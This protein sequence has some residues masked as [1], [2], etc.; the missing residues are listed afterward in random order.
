M[1]LNI[2][3][4]PIEVCK[5]SIKNMHLYVKP[6]NGNVTVSAPLSMSDEAI[7]RFVRTKVSWIKR[8]VEKFD[9]QPRQ[10]PREYI[11]GETLYVWGKQYYLR[12]EY[13]NK[14]SLVLSGDKAILTVRKESTALQRE[15]FIREW[16]RGLL[17]AEINAL[18]PKCEKTTGLKAT[19]WQTKYMTSR[20]GTCNTQS[21]KIWLNLQLAKKTPQCLEY[22]IIHELVHLV[23]KN[24]NERFVSLM[25]KF[26]PMWRE[27]KATLNGQTLDYME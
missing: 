11:S 9:S 10:S 6:P 5:K 26:M 25:D 24:H 7:E 23:E 2:S 13:G 22:V 14:N 17:K 8:Q 27:I 1:A 21:G 19:S 4:I 16:Y 20:W 12:T 15:T 3:G 18:L